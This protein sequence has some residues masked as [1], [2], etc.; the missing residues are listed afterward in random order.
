MKAV[1]IEFWQKKILDQMSTVFQLGLDSFSYGVNK[2]SQ[3]SALGCGLARS[4]L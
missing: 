3:A 2:S 4:R 1:L